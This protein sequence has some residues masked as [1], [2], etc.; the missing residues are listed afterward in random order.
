MAAN[1]T[2]VTGKDHQV[3]VVKPTAYG[4]FLRLMDVLVDIARNDYRA[5][6]TA[7]DVEDRS[8]G[9]SHD[10]CRVAGPEL[11]PGHQSATSSRGKPR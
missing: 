10:S 6:S 4:S 2:H 8:S 3:E 5:G 1:D 7:Q 9:T 11:Q